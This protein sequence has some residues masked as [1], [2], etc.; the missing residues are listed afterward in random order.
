MLDPQWSGHRPRLSHGVR[1]E[2]PG[3]GPDPAKPPPGVRRENRKPALTPRSLSEFQGTLGGRGE[4][5]GGI[6]L[7]G[8]GIGTLRREDPHHA[9]PRRLRLPRTERP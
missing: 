2:K 3:A 7:E 4:A 1:R 8:A 9:D 6:F 5:S